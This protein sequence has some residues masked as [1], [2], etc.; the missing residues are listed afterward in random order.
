[1][2]DALAVLGAVCLMPVVML[3]DPAAARRCGVSGLV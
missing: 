3:E 2:T 1:M